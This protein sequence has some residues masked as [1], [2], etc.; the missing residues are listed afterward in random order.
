MTNIQFVMKADDAKK[1]FIRLANKCEDLRPVWEKFIPKY[2][3]IVS[4]NFEAKGKIMEGAAWAPYTKPYL[5]WKKKHY[6]GKPK[7]VITEKLKTAAINF[8]AKPKKDNLTMEID[9]DDYFFYVS[10]RKTN[11]RKYFYTKNKTL[12]VIAGR[13]LTKIAND[14]LEKVLK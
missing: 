6:S 13:L 9:G 14:E 7:L 4:Q 10:E 5:K 8:V 1:R 12:P 2:R 11:P 3:E